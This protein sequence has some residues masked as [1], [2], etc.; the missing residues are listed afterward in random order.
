MSSINADTGDLN[1][2]RIFITA[3]KLAKLDSHLYLS[4]TL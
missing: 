2:E 1:N 3:I 4:L